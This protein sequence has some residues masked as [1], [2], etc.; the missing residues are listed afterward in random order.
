MLPPAQQTFRHVSWIYMLRKDDA[1]AILQEQGEDIEGNMEAIR[2]RLVQL[3]SEGRI[4]Q[5]RGDQAFPTDVTGTSQSVPPG[6]NTTSTDQ[7]TLSGDNTG[8]NVEVMLNAP[9]NPPIEQ[10]RKW[11]SY[12][13]GKDIYTFLE[14]LNELSMAYGI[15]E[16]Q[17]LP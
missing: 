1:I 14:R 4:Y 6:G 17:L 15:T 13:D 8:S 11:N 9:R 3:A 5:T 2:R 7:S 16:E 10:V 12:F